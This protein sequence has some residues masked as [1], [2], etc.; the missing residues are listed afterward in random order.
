[1]RKG[2][3]LLKLFFDLDIFLEESSYSLCHPFK[4]CLG[5]QALRM[6]SEVSPHACA[7][8]T[9]PYPTQILLFWVCSKEHSYSMQNNARISFPALKNHIL[10]LSKKGSFFLLRIRNKPMLHFLL[11]YHAQTRR[12]TG[13]K[14][15][16]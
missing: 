4:S 2:M 12:K 13:L 9:T 8:S 11:F 3:L 15:H 16:L 7:L 1:M 14:E 10:P 6:Y 5:C